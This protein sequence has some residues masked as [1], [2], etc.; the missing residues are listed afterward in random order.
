M[1]D[2]TLPTREPRLTAYAVARLC[3]EAN[4]AFT[5]YVGDPVAPVWD[6]L[7]EQ[8]QR[9]CLAGVLFTIKNPDAGDAASHESWMK[10][11]LADGWQHGPIIDSDART[12]PNL[13]PFDELSRD[14]KF[15][16]RLFRTIVLAA[17]LAGEDQL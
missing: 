5:R 4:R 9:S 15:K 14:Q 11:R 12:H 16:D 1:S 8:R 10:Q 13:V 2:Q 7:D 6:D 3:H 17:I